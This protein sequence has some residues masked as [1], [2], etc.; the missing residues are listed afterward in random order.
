VI[1]ELDLVA[2]ERPVPEF[3]LEPGDIGTVVFVYPDGGYELEFVRG[4][5]TTVAVVTV[6]VP[7]VRP[8]GGDEILHVRALSA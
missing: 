8:V 3:G 5:G 2:L 4:D 1:R 7:E 6:E